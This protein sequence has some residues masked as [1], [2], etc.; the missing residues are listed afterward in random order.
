MKILLADPTGFCFGV[1]RAIKQLERALAEYG[2]VY[3]TGS[4]I[5]N[6][7]E[8]ARLE[9]QGLVVVSRFTEIPAGTAVFIRAHGVE[10]E[11]Y[12]YLKGHDCKIIDGTCPF[13]KNAQEKAG[14]LEKEGYMVLIVGDTDHPE[15]K[16]IKG[17]VKGECHVVSSWQEASVY[18]GRN[19][20]GLLSQT[21]QDEDI[22]VKTVDKM[23]RCVKEV[24]VYNTICKA[25]VERQNAIRKLAERVDV[26]VVI[27]G[28]NSAN[29]SRLFDI[30]RSSGVK[31]FWIEHAEELDLS[32][33]DG[34]E[35]V[36]I[37]AGASTPEWL[38][39]EVQILLSNLQVVKGDG[40]R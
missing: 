25:T 18:C 19:K 5:H 38:I 14:L 1:K 13:V 39:N 23:I 12:A 9:K 36:G 15:I 3:S 4:P 33:L 22:F 26:V 20:I 37:A 10:P 17:F 11:A 29:T 24:K 35:I 40:K 2:T 27:G 30:A 8:V 34:A 6:P 7:Q 31:S 28:R 16:S 32:G 21:T